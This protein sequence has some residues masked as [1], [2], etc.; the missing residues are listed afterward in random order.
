MS[1]DPPQDINLNPFDDTQESL[2]PLDNLVCDIC[3]ELNLTEDVH[4]QK[5][6]ICEEP[7]CTHH[8]SIVD[9]SHCAECLNDVSV[10]F[11][12][13]KKTETHIN[14][15]TNTPYTRTRKARQ[16]KIGGLHWLFAQR[17]INDL[18]D[19]ELDLAIQY[20]RAIYD[21]MLYERE[22]RR[23]EHFHRNAKR[24]FK[25]NNPST[26]VTSTTT[27]TKSKKISGQKPKTKEVNAGALLEGLLKS[28]MTIEQIKAMMF[29]KK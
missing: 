17:K 26:T 11:E 1:N 9:P 20:H 14:H 8:A 23:T 13:I 7:Y 21:S 19:I 5:C 18:N 29:T 28:G 15:D 22:K 10:T 27:V 3:L 16:I 2:E 4:I 25:I 24:Q 12:V 6:V